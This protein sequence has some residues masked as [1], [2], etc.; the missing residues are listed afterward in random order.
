MIRNA[1]ENLCTETTLNAVKTAID[2]VK[3][4]IDSVATLL[5]GISGKITECNTS[6]V[7]IVSAPATSVS[8]F[9]STQAVSGPVT[10]T[11]LRASAVPVSLADH[12]TETTLL[13]LKGV[14]EDILTASQFIGAAVDGINS[15]S[16]A[17]VAQD[18]TVVA[19]KELTDTIVY[20]LQ[21][22][23]TKMPAVNKQGNLHVTNDINGGSLAITSNA[24]AEQ[25]QSSFSI[26]SSNL[27][28]SRLHEPWNKSDM[29]SARLYSNIIIS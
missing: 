12:S 24:Y 2:L 4:G 16:G 28:R 6:E 19:I 15:K 13:L 26:P 1:F 8:N 21:T 17:K 5:S 20:E 22:I 18:A 25:F 10:D 14:S 27:F 23:F 3:A 11:Q 9:P 29:A 7:T